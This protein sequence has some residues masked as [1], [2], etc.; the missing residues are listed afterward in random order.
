M[1]GGVSQAHL[2]HEAGMFI[3]PGTDFQL[4]FHLDDGVVLHKT[5]LFGEVDHQNI[6][7]PVR[8]GGAERA[9]SH[10]FAGEHEEIRI[11]LQRR[12]HEAAYGD[13]AA[14]KG[15]HLVGKAQAERPAPAVEFVEIQAFFRLRPRALRSEH[16]AEQ[17][18][19]PGFHV[20]SHREK[21][22]ERG[23]GVSQRTPFRQKAPRIF[24][25]PYC[26][27]KGGAFPLSRRHHLP[28]AMASAMMRKISVLFMKP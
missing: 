24:R 10:G 9:E 17:K 3:R 13:A 4:A 21:G 22:S 12:S 23:A 11:R 14:F 8:I 18:N 20:A 16:K 1:E 15:K 19:Q 26:S 6:V 25:A 2:A 5:L 7:R 28:R 27:W